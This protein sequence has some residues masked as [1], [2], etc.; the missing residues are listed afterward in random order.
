MEDCVGCKIEYNTET[1]TVLLETRTIPYKFQ[2]ETIKSLVRL[3][4]EAC[5]KAN[6]L[7]AAA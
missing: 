2:F 5:I 4:L 6:L 3:N 7:I 1:P